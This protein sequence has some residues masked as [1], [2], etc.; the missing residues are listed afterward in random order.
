MPKRFGLDLASL[1]VDLSSLSAAESAVASFKRLEQE[2]RQLHVGALAASQSIAKQF[3][4]AEQGVAGLLASL[5]PDPMI[6]HA[7]AAVLADFGAQAS[8]E[9]SQ[10]EA[11]A[12]VNPLPGIIEQYSEA[13]SIR[14][15]F[16]AAIAQHQSGVNQLI[17]DAQAS[18]GLFNQVEHLGDQWHGIGNFAQE[19]IRQSQ[20]AATQL[21]SVVSQA[22]SSL[23]Q[24][25][26]ITL[27]DL[28]D[29]VRT[30]LPIN[31]L[32]ESVRQHFDQLG[33]QTASELN[34]DALFRTHLDF[35]GLNAW[36]QI[37][38]QL[39]RTV[40]STLS[41]SW[42]DTAA[43]L[44]HVAWEQVSDL[45]ALVIPRKRK[46][47]RVKED[48]AAGKELAPNPDNVTL[49]QLIAAVKDDT[50]ALSKNARSLPVWTQWLLAIATVL[51]VWYAYESV[52]KGR[53]AN[54][55]SRK[56]N[57]LSEEANGLA[58]E[59]LQ[60]DRDQAQREQH[61]S[62]AH[63]WAVVAEST[64]LYAEPTDDASVLITLPAGEKVGVFERREGWALVECSAGSGA[65]LRGWMRLSTIWLGHE[66]I[67]VELINNLAGSATALV[68]SERTPATPALRSFPVVVSEP[69]LPKLIADAGSRAGN[70]FVEYF[71]ATIRNPN[72]RQAYFH[73][74][75]SFLEHCAALER[76]LSSIKPVHVAAYIER[77]AQTR[78]APT[79]K[80]HLA[81]IR[82]LFDHLVVG[83]VV[84][85]NPAASV[86]GPKHVVTEGQTPIL[87]ADESRKVFGTFDTDQL[88]HL[89][90][91][92]I[93]G[94]MAHSFARVSAV[95]KLKVRDY[96]RQGARA[97]FV[98]DEKGGR[99]NRVPAHH[100]AAEYVDQYL[101]AAGIAGER[102]SHLFRSLGR[103][104]Q[105][106]GAGAVTARPMSR[107]D[108]L[109]MV[110]RR[111]SDAGLPPEI[112][113]RSFRGSGITNYLGNGGI[114]E[115][116]QRLAGHASIRTTQLY[117]RR[118]REIAQAEIAQAE[119]ER[120]HLT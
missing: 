30:T 37:Q 77:L 85:V 79:V 51:A 111:M 42:R 3:N 11:L 113:C 29:T 95:T 103:G 83:Q 76:D 15:T 41:P 106:K 120:I 74:C 78:S 60:L 61:G 66:A 24:A 54:E 26:S 22:R 116:A 100:Q 56:A 110:R 108:V 71:T 23:E 80:Q 21:Q 96:Y 33:L 90:D 97:W 84:E 18:L 13:A 98:L 117:D 114:L 49:G 40:S 119:I 93:L 107:H 88:A 55:L 36:D 6:E 27:R 63:N 89:R 5:Q 43:A 19:H 86:R 115:V 72:T 44:K 45:A 118:N 59:Q 8:I 52:Q 65:L 105:K 91:R 81:A 70:R 73:A 2:Q 31:G 101:A 25:A 69:D 12:V 4:S 53:E 9:R 104:R 62:G 16:E 39:Q 87:D 46:R 82:G 35:K 50:A 92:A 58:R 32:F 109:A 94:V 75:T 48:S 64:F 20:V 47:K 112:S 57:E 67:F 1:G 99:Q 17:A 34:V 102:D 10:A 28:A 68:I 14:R 38:E 7:R